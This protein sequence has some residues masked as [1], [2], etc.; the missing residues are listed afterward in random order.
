M[1]R[2]LCLLTLIMV[3]GGCAA[4]NYSPIQIVDVTV[5]QTDPSQETCESTLAG[6][7][8]VTATPA[9]V[10]TAALVTFFLS[11][12]AQDPGIGFEDDNDNGTGQNAFEVTQVQYKYDSPS[13]P[14][15]D[16]TRALYFIVPAN[17]DPTAT[18]LQE[19]IL[20]D[21]ALGVLSTATI[22]E[23]AVI[24]SHITLLGNYVSQSKDSGSST[25]VAF[26]LTLIP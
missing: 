14:L 24:T 19:F 25:T 9:T 6:I 2:T 5:P 8:R 23:P 1:K 3:A 20:G 21:G 7:T 11:N 18:C 13:I 17:A 12:V 15:T 4:A 16:E 10:T 22:T 26:P